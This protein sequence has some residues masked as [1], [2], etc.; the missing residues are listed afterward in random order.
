M[1]PRTVCLPRDAIVATW[2][3]R[4]AVLLVGETS[5]EDVFWTE[6]GEADLFGA[7]APDAVEPG[8]LLDAELFDFVH[9]VLLHSAPERFAL[10]YRLAWRLR[11]EPHLLSM[12]TDPDVHRAARMALEVRHDMHKMKAFVRFR[13]VATAAGEHFVAWFEPEHDIVEAVAPFFR[14]RFAQMRWSILTPRRC[15]HWDGAALRF[16]KGARRED[17]PDG[18]PL[19]AAWKT[20]YTSIF[21]PARVMPRAMLKGMPKKY[22]RNMPETALIPQ[23]L[24][25]APA[26]AAA[27]IAQSPTQPSRAPGSG[28]API[29][30]LDDLTRLAAAAQSCA[31][32]PLHRDA[33][34]A[35]PGEGPRDAAIMIV[36]EQPGDHEDLVGKPFVGPAGKLLDEALRR[37]G[38]ARDKLYVTNAVKHFKFEPRGKRRIHRAPDASE[39][40]HCRWW[41]DQERAL[42]RPRLIVTLGATALR[43]VLGR[44]QAVNDIRGRPLSLDGDTRLLA[45]VHPAFLLR[46]IDETEKRREWR[47]FLDDLALMRA[48][49]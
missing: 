5:P 40:D 17:A 15:A 3:A 39:T 42:V 28:A 30:M 21:N 29:P 14:R 11:R 44:A 48:L 22:W 47:R 18:D 10:A 37:C 27:M 16:T 1:T 38:V 4:A 24:R 7:A 49:A 41:L 25:D 12:A 26:R 35:V 33:T 19:E 2:R 43:G 45:T 32:C 46:L 31:R 6:E 36:G 34:Q 23:M 9:P 13:A 20:Y 8:A